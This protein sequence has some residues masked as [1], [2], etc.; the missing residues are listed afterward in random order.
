MKPNR[1][2]CS[3]ARLWPSDAASRPSSRHCAHRHACSSPQAPRSASREGALSRKPETHDEHSSP[4]TGATHAPSASA[5]NEAEAQTLSASHGAPQSAERTSSSSEKASSSARC[6]ASTGASAF[7]SADAFSRRA[8]DMTVRRAPHANRTEAHAHALVCASV[9]T[10]PS[11]AA[12]RPER[13]VSVTDATTTDSRSAETHSSPPASDRASGASSSRGRARV[14]G[15]GRAVPRR[16]SPVGPSRRKQSCASAP[17]AETRTRTRNATRE[18]CAR[19]ATTH[20]AWRTSSRC[21]DGSGGPTRRR[22][23][24]WRSSGREANHKKKKSRAS[25][26]GATNART[27][28]RFPRGT[29]FI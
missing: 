23:A 25:R 17:R 21:A 5:E 6:R 18:A 10:A 8:R 3:R 26:L 29:M 1:P 12:P 2:S 24:A 27:S 16:S 20:D 4:H 22:R 13:S 19:I 7:A 9:G 15:R 28:L 14:R 11:V